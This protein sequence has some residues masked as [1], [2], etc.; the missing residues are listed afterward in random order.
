MPEAKC[1]FDFRA[2]C[3]WYAILFASI[4]AVSFQLRRHAPPPA[5]RPTVICNS[6][7]HRL[8]I[9][10][11]QIAIF[12]QIKLTIVPKT[13]PHNKLLSLFGALTFSLESP[14]ELAWL[15]V[16]SRI[17]FGADPVHPNARHWL[18]SSGSRTRRQHA[19]THLSLFPFFLYSKKKEKSSHFTN[20]DTSS[21]GE[22]SA[23]PPRSTFSLP[24]PPL[25]LPR[26]NRG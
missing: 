11:P 24:P 1:N 10:P 12:K 2:A 13:L 17:S 7:S 21:P 20:E 8:R 14:V 18:A 25:H 6:I 19:P 23:Q 22:S 16:L 26:R 9:S 15:G 5:L 3:T 4:G